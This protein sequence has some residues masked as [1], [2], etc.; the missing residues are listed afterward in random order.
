M[1]RRMP[2]ICT[3]QGMLLIVGQI[4]GKILAVGEVLDVESL[5]LNDLR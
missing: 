1:R 2:G 4:S 3:R 5:R